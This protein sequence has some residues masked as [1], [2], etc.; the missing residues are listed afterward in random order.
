MSVL[1]M[2]T[3]QIIPPR[4]LAV[5]NHRVTMED[6]LDA[7]KEFW[8]FPVKIW[9]DHAEQKLKKAPAIK[10]ANGGRGHLDA[11]KDLK[12]VTELFA[13]AVGWNAVGIPTGERNGIDVVD[14][15]LQYEAA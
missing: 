11:S 5:L 8:I 15:D 2:H 14:E 9:W 12:D 3:Q 13:R 1:Q 6:V 7:A 10:K 4:V